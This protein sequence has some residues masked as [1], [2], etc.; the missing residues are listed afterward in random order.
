MNY[1][2]GAVQYE[3]KNYPA[4]LES[5]KKVLAAAPDD[6]RTLFAAARVYFDTGDY[7]EARK[8]YLKLETILPKNSSELNTVEKNLSE[9]DRISR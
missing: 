8:I 3:A 1:L 6:A 9:L 2:N 5:F 7:K 4:A